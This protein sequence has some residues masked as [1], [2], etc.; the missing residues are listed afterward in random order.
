MIVAHDTA[1]AMAGARW[2]VKM[3]K[4]EDIMVLG[5]LTGTTYGESIER[6]QSRYGNGEL[7]SALFATLLPLG[8]ALAYWRTLE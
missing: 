7:A 1:S 8:I 2:V 5:D 4:E 6:G 3:A